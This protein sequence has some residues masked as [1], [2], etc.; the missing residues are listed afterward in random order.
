M[1]FD[2][3]GWR[4]VQTSLCRWWCSPVAGEPQKVNPQTKQEEDCNKWEW[5]CQTAVCSQAAQHST[6]QRGVIL[7]SW[8]GNCIWHFTGHYASQTFW[9]IPPVGSNALDRGIS[10]DADGP[11]DCAVPSKSGCGHFWWLVRRNGNAVAHIINV[12]LHRAGLVLGLVTSTGLSSRYLSRSTQPGH[13]SVGMCSEY[14]RWFWPPLGKKRRV[15]RSSW[16]GTR[17][18]GFTV[19]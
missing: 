1:P 14:W 2:E 5:K 3:A 8:E 9:F 15:L 4:F 17:T 12:T 11:M 13:P 6:D 19:Y 18:A 7:Q 10:S 16:P